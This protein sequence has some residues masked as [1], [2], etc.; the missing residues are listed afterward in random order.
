MLAHKIG[1]DGMQRSVG[2]LAVLAVVATAV[3]L[4]MRLPDPSF[5]LSRMM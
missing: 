5:A 3:W 1:G 4:F 2:V